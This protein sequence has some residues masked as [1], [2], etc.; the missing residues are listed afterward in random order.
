MV[1]DPDVVVGDVELN[2]VAI[3]LDLMEPA[4]AARHLLDEGR[5][6]G[7]DEAGEFGLRADGGWLLTL[8]GHT[9]LHRTAP[10]GEGSAEAANLGG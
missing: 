6:R 9:E 4:L 8:E 2:A 5:E 1:I 7:F 10:A 3:E